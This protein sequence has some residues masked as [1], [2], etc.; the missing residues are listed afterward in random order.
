MCT[1]E[2]VCIFYA[3]SSTGYANRLT[4][5]PASKQQDMTAQPP[6]LSPSPTL[7]T[8][9]N[10][11]AELP[12]EGVDTP[13][14]DS[15]ILPRRG[16]LKRRVPRVIVA[17]LVR[18]GRAV[19]VIDGGGGRGGRGGGRRGG[20]RGWGGCL[21]R[22]ACPRTR[23]TASGGGGGSSSSKGAAPTA[24]AAARVAWQDC[25]YTQRGPDWALVSHVARPNVL[26]KPGS[27]TLFG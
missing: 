25:T 7:L 17:L 14:R 1:T 9:S 4:L 13:H 20:R 24:A 18:I 10:A 3:L 8:H 2:C 11:A 27:N 5:H 22:T 16:R 26:P 23:R 21:R 6:C 12:G 19:G 15:L